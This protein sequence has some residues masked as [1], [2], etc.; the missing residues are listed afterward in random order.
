MPFGKHRGQKLK[1]IPI[2]YLIWLLDNYDGLRETTR[3][4]IENFVA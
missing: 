2:D 4:V 1:D 3:K